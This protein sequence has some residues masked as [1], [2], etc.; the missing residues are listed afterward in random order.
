MVFF[1]VI[2]VEEK[3]KVL[4]DTIKSLIKEEIAKRDTTSQ[5]Q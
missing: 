4:P 2:Q 3:M 5:F 1:N